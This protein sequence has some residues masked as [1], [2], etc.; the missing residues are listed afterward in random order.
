MY[1]K[2]YLRKVVC[3]CFLKIT[4]CFYQ[5]LIITGETKTKQFNEIHTVTSVSWK[6]DQFQFS[7]HTGRIIHKIKYVIKSR[8]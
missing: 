7:Y 1:R 6:L 8:I 2:L 4:I 3:V 5:I